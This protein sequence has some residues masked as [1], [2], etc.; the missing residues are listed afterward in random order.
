MVFARLFSKSKER[1]SRRALTRDTTAFSR[2]LSEK[3][4]EY[5]H[6]SYRQKLDPAGDLRFQIMRLPLLVVTQ[7]FSKVAFSG[8]RRTGTK[9]ELNVKEP[10]TVI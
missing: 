3:S 5:P 6:K 9:T 4:R 1:R 8:A 2:I 10:L 7:L